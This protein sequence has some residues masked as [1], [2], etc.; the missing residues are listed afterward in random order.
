[1]KPSIY[2][3]KYISPSIQY[4]RRKQVTTKVRKKF[5]TPEEFLGIYELY[6]NIRCAEDSLFVLNLIETSKTYR[7]YKTNP[8]FINWEKQMSVESIMLILKKDPP[9]AL[10]DDGYDDPFFSRLMEWLF[11]HTVHSRSLLEFRDSQVK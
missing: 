11:N 8:I 6:K 3:S 5:M 4:Y 10:I 9:A 2:H 1:M 7:H